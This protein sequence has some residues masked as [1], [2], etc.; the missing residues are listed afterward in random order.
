MSKENQKKDKLKDEDL[1][2]AKGGESLYP[3][4]INKKTFNFLGY[5]APH[6][7]SLEE[8]QREQEKKKKKKSDN[9]DGD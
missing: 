1:E 8:F 5:A 2:N 6:I 9:S 7:K 3:P 4:L